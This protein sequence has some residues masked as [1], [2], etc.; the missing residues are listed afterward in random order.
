MSCKLLTKLPQRRFSTL[1]NLVRWSKKLCKMRLIS[2]SKHS[3]N[4]SMSLAFLL[5]I[6]RNRLSS[7][8]S[9]PRSSLTLFKRKTTRSVRTK[10]RSR[11]LRM[12]SKLSKAKS[13]SSKRKRVDCKRRLSTAKLRFFVWR[14]LKWLSR[15]NWQS[16]AT[17]LRNKKLR[18]DSKPKSNKIRWLKLRKLSMHSSWNY[19]RKKQRLKVSNKRWLKWAQS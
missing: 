2:R 10:R 8:L 5:K 3:R 16:R 17:R 7:R 18:S 11:I 4:R 13:M 6:G 15:E 12:R 19:L 1:S 9:G 14:T